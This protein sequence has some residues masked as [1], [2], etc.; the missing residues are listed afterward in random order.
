MSCSPR[1]PPAAPTAAQELWHGLSHSTQPSPTAAQPHTAASSVPYG[2][3]VGAKPSPTHCYG[4]P[5]TQN[6]SSKSG[7]MEGEGQGRAWCCMGS[8]LTI[9]IDINLIEHHVCELLGCHGF[10]A[11]VDGSDGLERKD[12][13][14]S[15]EC[16]AGFCITT[17]SSVS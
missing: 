10:V 16:C 9:P 2:R 6:C 12:T 14:N 17:R 4:A 13:R 8:F 3:A 15:T 7:C 5:N 11:A 1:P